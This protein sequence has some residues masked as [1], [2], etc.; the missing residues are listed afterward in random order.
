MVGNGG[1]VKERGTGF[2]RCSYFWT[3]Q[4]RFEQADTDEERRAYLAISRE[5]IG[6]AHEQITEL[7]AQVS[8][9]RQAFEGRT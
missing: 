2:Y 1:F 6:Q 8:K 7:R 4:K 3:T 9:A 5:I